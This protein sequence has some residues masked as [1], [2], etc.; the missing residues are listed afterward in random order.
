MD[1]PV[2]NPTRYRLPTTTI[3]PVASKRGEYVKR[4]DWKEM[5]ASRDEYREKCVM[6]EEMAT[7]RGETIRVLRAK[8]KRLSPASQ[9]DQIARNMTMIARTFR[10]NPN[11]WVY[12]ALNRIQ[13]LAHEREARSGTVIDPRI[14][15]AKEILNIV[16]TEA[17]K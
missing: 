10:G 1:M 4:G 9:A 8:V 3:S 14:I 16:S 13:A 7:E 12:R 15:D 2:E 5:R 6:L 17:L 11:E